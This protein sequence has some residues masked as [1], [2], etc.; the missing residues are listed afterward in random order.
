MTHSHVLVVGGG[1][2]GAVA[3]CLLARAGLSVVLL[4][5]Q[6]RPR[7]KVCGEFLSVQGVALLHQCGLWTV[8]QPGRLKPV[9][10]VTLGRDLGAIHLP[11]PPLATEQRS[12]AVHRQQWDASLLQA[13]QQAGVAVY[14]G[15][16]V[17]SV[18]PL[19]QP[20]E[21]GWQVTTGTGE[22]WTT[23]LLVGA[24]GC[25][26]TVAR[27]L[28]LSRRVATSQNRVA[29]RCF[30][31]RTAEGWPGNS[32]VMQPLPPAGYWGMTPVEASQWN[33]SVVLPAAVVG[34]LLNRAGKDRRTGLIQ[35]FR[36]YW[37]CCPTLQQAIAWPQHLPPVTATAPVTHPVKGGIGALAVCIGDA[38]GYQEPLTGE[39]LTVALWS[40]NTL[41]AL[42]SATWQQGR[43]SQRQ[44][45]LHHYARLYR[46]HWALRHGWAQT[47]LWGIQHPTLTHKTLA[48]LA[49]L[50]ATARQGLAG[51]M[52]HTYGS[53]QLLSEAPR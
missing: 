2:A 43:W 32:L 24:D 13:A 31:P 45:T 18:S 20:G 51:L 15:Q 49:S 5:A 37:E 10:G 27:A 39:G 11:F 17:V 34:A 25:N 7:R 46:G 1:P 41:A 16:R 50:P 23:Q 47:L 14:R 21:T 33:A 19:P 44:E 53:S 29:L 48:V 12:M 36:Q 42:L 35:V 52:N 28:Q 8:T 9:T 3:A 26:S 38:G 40:A 6:T 22:T 30:L 4:E